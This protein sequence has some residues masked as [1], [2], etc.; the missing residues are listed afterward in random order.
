MVYQIYDHFLMVYEIFA[1]IIMIFTS[2]KS[3]YA[4]L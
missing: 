2:S 4:A 1:V 3:E